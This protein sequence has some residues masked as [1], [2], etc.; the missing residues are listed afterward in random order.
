MW[1]MLQHH[2]AEDFVIATGVTTTVREFIFKTFKELGITYLNLKEKGK[3][4]CSSD[5]I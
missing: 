5:K 4:V 3:R 2:K 1:L